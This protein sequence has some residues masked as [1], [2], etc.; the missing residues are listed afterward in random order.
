MR[1]PKTSTDYIRNAQ[2]VINQLQIKTTRS[3][4]ALKDVKGEKVFLGDLE[5]ISLIVDVFI[6]LTDRK[7]E[8][9]LFTHQN[10]RDR[11]ES[12]GIAL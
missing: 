4:D 5:S 7:L 2:L 6:E 9:D 8:E 12:I 3:S 10:S 1:E 11:S